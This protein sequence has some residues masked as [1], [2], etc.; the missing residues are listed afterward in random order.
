[1]NIKQAKKIPIMYFFSDILG[2]Q[3]RQHGGDILYSSPFRDDEHPSYS[4]SIEKN[5][6]YDFATGES[7]DI[8]G[9][10]S[11]YYNLSTSEALAKLEKLMQN[12]LP[13]S[14]EKYTPKNDIKRTYTGRKIES[15]ANTLKTSPNEEN[16]SN[17]NKKAQIK[18]IK[19]LFYY[20][21][22]NYIKDVRKISIATAEIYLKEAHYTFAYDTKVYFGIT[23]QNISN[24]HEI[25]RYSTKYEK[26]FKTAIGNKDITYIQGRDDTDKALVF[27]GMFDFLSFLEYKKVSKVEEDTIILNSISCQ[28]RATEFIKQ[29]KYKEV[30]LYLDND[31][32]GVNTKE[33]MKNALERKQD[34]DE[35]NEKRNRGTRK[36]S[37]V[38]MVKIGDIMSKIIGIT[39]VDM[40][41]LYEGFKDVNEWWVS[42]SV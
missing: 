19:E 20:P 31:E 5:I 17:F 34:F 23:W 35:E 21:L 6:S 8:V 12:T 11:D 32:E 14:V 15:K 26:S 36:F 3:G 42:F 33:K 24:G 28:K 7:R 37:D 2:L 38:G 39:V 16:T 18:E 41:G 30:Y 9:A 25:T 10:I 29:K 13:K 4:V 1:M 40:S 22:K 27:E